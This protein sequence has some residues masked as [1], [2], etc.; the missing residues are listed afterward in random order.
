MNLSEISVDRIISSNSYPDMADE[1]VCL[2][3]NS[4]EGLGFSSISQEVFNK[5][6]VIF[7][8]TDF[9][10]F[11]FDSLK[12]ISNIQH[13]LITHHSDYSITEDIYRNKPSCIKN[14]FAQNV[15][16]E[17]DDLIPIPIALQPYRNNPAGQKYI[18][19]IKENLDSMRDSKKQNKIYCA[20]SN[21]NPE[22]SSIISKIENS[23][24]EY[25]QQI[26]PIEEYFINISTH[27]F[28]I[29][30]PGNGIDCHRTWEVLNVG[31]I[32]IVKKNIIYDSW[33]GLPILQVDDWSDINSD[34]LQEFASREFDYEMLDYEYWNN[35][36]RSTI[37]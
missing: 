34:M 13:T 10:G 14:W 17:S 30:P 18:D 28:V 20:W 21:T 29:S 7:C 27:R 16:F 25:T 37:K 4:P 6:R 23:G 5:S 36:I 19:Y 12:H 2:M 26:A 11:L 35:R 24:M 22:R 15:A 33:E 9:L 1:I 31:S 8:K 32:P 3:E